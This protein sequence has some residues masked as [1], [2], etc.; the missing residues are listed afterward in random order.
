MEGM[1]G[2]VLI[3]VLVKGCGRYEDPN[4]AT[5]SFSMLLGDA[6]HLDRTVSRRFQ[7]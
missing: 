5:S 1:A 3:L 2:L 4:S 6:P 7:K